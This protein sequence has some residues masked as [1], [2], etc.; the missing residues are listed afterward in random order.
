MGLFA[1]HLSYQLWK[2]D[3]TCSTDPF[4]KFSSSDFQWV[5]IANANGDQHSALFSHGNEVAIGA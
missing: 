5:E 1:S 4:I 2:E 3:S